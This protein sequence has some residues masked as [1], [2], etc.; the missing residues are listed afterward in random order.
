MLTTPDNALTWKEANISAASQ[1]VAVTKAQN[2]RSFRYRMLGHAQTLLIENDVK[3]GRDDNLHRTRKCHAVRAFGQENIMLQLST[4][5]QQSE[6]KITQVQT[7]GCVWSCP[8]CV[9]TVM[10]EKAELVLKALKWAE[11]SNL[12]PV[13][14]TLTAQHNIYMKL[15]DFSAKVKKSYQLFTNR[16]KWRK[17]KELFGVAHHIS[18]VE[19]TYGSHGWH[20]HKH[21][22]LFLDKNV[23]SQANPYDKIQEFLQRDW[24]DCLQKNQLTGKDGIALQVSTHHN[25]GEKYLSKMGIKF[26]EK[27]LVYEVTSAE[28]KSSVT[29]FDLLKRSYYGDTAAGALYLEFVETMTGENFMT[30]SHGLH[31]LIDDIELEKEEIDKPEIVD[32]MWFTPKAWYIVK[33]AK[34]YHEILDIAATS[35]DVRAVRELIKHRARE[36]LDAGHWIPPRDMKNEVVEFYNANS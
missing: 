2:K 28:T 19:V 16:R 13:M 34:I 6:A 1:N 22:I 12:I 29:V 7:C 11:K 15:S 9:A 35:R 20:Y 18:N 33:K 27:N 30:C 21:L 5:P 10:L 14:V 4:D 3:S 32:W 23:L 8:V 31:D 25:I 36:L 24:L 17:F 26:D